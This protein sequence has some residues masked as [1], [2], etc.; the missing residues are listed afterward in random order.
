MSEDQPADEQNQNHSQLRKAIGVGAELVGAAASGALG[1]LF[2]GPF[3]AAGAGA[4]GVVISKTLLEVGDEVCDRILSPREKVR[5]GA[6]VAIAADRTQE[7]L[8]HGDQIRTDDFIND[9]TSRPPV[10]EVTEGLLLAAQKSY[11]EKKVPFIGRLLANLNFRPDLS[12][13]SA[14][15]LVRLSDQLSYQHLC[16]LRLCHDNASGTPLKGGQAGKY[17]KSPEHA[18]LLSDLLYLERLGLINNSGNAVL[19]ITGINPPKMQLQLFG[20]HLFSLMELDLIPQEDLTGLRAIF[21]APDP[22]YVTTQTLNVNLTAPER[23]T[24]SPVVGGINID[25]ITRTRP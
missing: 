7:R 6:A 24:P 15:L 5:V 12:V 11:E 16:L 3:G 13:Q 18:A 19:D 9:G 14:S 2:A 1:F 17:V 21:D 4:A 25:G 10:S 8:K 20:S 22:T 23:F